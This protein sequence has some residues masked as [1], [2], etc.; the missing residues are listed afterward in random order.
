MNPINIFLR[1]NYDEYPNLINVTSACCKAIVYEGDIC[2][3]CFKKCEVIETKEKEAVN[4]N[5]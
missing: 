4:E 2:S 5:N 1:D 3:K